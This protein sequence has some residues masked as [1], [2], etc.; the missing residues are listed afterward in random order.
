MDL[1]QLQTRLL[2]AFLLFGLI[3][4]RRIFS[5]EDNIPN[6]KSSMFQRVKHYWNL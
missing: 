6:K 5:A 1:K 3:G 4:D 2:I